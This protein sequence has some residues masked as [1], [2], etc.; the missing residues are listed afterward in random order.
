MSMAKVGSAAVVLFGAGGLAVGA[1][2]VTTAV[3]A[4]QCLSGV[5]RIQAEPVRTLYT[6]KSEWIPFTT[7][8][9]RTEDAQGDRDA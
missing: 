9:T 3:P 8:C 4:G 7:T 2:V 5:Y 6:V 1:P